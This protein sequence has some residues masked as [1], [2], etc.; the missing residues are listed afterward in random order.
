[1]NKKDVHIH[2]HSFY[3]SVYSY[4]TMEYKHRYGQILADSKLSEMLVDFISGYYWG[5]N[6]IQFTAGEVVNL[7]KSKCKD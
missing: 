2:A 6:T 3:M 5:G 4:I 7:I 1:M